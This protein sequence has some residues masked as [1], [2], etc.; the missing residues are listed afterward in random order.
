[1]YARIKSAWA[2]SRLA[3]HAAVRRQRCEQ[4]HAQ[5]RRLGH[6]HREAEVANT[7]L[8]MPVER[9]PGEA[10]VCTEKVVTRWE[11]SRESNGHRRWALVYLIEYDP[12]VERCEIQPAPISQLRTRSIS[13]WCVD[14][15]VAGVIGSASGN[16]ENFYSIRI[17][18]VGRRRQIRTEE[19]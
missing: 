3:T 7:P 4:C 19:A 14:G 9:N 13:G 2:P 10:C 5:H 1:C 12:R 8:L 15:E 11:P 6:L 16:V 18:E 17:K